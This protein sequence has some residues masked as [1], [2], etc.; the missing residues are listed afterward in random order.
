M[1]VITHAP[2][3]ILLVASVVAPRTLS[4]ADWRLL[5]AAMSAEIAPRARTAVVTVR[6]RLVAD[7]EA[8]EIRLRGLEFF[9]TELDDISASVHGN[10]APFRFERKAAPA[11]AGTI[12]I[13]PGCRGEDE[14]E[15]TLRY[16]VRQAIGLEGRRFDAVLPLLVPEAEPP[17]AREGFF[18]S[19][20]RMPAEYTVTE[21]FPTVPRTTAVEGETK[22]VSLTLQVMPAM[23]RWRGTSGPPPLLTFGRSLSLGVA[24]VILIL[25]LMG[26]GRLRRAGSP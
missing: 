5:G 7:G 12:S 2:T 20:T 8:A 1:P 23:V 16:T 26:Y 25:V 22:R 13:P 9:G 21:S 17:A 3:L 4:A 24:G 15:I 10:R 6:Y 11:V 14:L 18:T 19:E